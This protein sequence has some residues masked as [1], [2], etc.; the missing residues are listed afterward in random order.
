MRTLRLVVPA[1]VVCAALSACGATNGPAS[2]GTPSTATTEPTPVSPSA[3]APSTP[4][5]VP[6]PTLKPPGGPSVPPPVGETELTGTITAGVEP[7]CLLLDGYLLVGGPRDVLAP[8]ARVTVNG[9]VEKG[10]MTT[11]QQGTPFVVEG[12]H[13]S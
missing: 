2:T 1:L 4:A 5:T 8:G 9:R 12:A 11:C 6:S 7:N 10:L 13:R 3:P